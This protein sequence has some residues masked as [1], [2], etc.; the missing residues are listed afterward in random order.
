M[1]P[2]FF[3][4]SVILQSAYCADGLRKW[5]MYIQGKNPHSNVATWLNL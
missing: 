1:R 5:H 4:L 2:V 3:E